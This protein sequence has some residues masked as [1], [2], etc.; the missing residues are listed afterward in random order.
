[1]MDNSAKEIER[2]PLVSII[3]VTYNS[4]MFIID[5][6]DSVKNQNYG[7]IELI[8]TDDHSKDDTVALI[9]DWIKENAASFVHCELVTSPVN[10][11]ITPNINRALKYISG[12]WVKV[13]PGDDLLFPD[14]ISNLLNCEID[15]NVGLIYSRARAFYKLQKMDGPAFGAALAKPY[16]RSLLLDNPIPAMATLIRRD[17]VETLDGYDERYPFIDDYPMWFRIIKEKWEIKFLECV[18]AG[19]RLHTQNISKSG[20]NPYYKSLYKFQKEN[21]L[22]KGLKYGFIYLTYTRYLDYLIYRI[23]EKLSHPTAIKVAN[24]LNFLK[25]S[26]CWD[27]VKVRIGMDQNFH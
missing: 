16:E 6:L 5:T 4:S 7:N 10:S 2:S 19:Y 17:V 15:A 3:V 12:D 21:L 11:G 13:L 24:G 14:S 20:Y 22:M 18:T 8:V 9:E 26:F 25:P 27:Y 1:M 23:K